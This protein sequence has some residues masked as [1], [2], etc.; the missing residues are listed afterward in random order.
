MNASI[1]A[2]KIMQLPLAI[3]AAYHLVHGATLPGFKSVKS[4][5]SIRGQRGPPVI[6]GR[7]LDGDAGSAERT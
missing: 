4:E 2:L 7:T 5:S 6:G 3:H 1:L